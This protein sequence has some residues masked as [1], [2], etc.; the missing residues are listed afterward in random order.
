MT[1]AIVVGIAAGIAAALL[2]LA[3]ASGAGLAF[4]L[5]AMTGLPIAIAGL[6]WGVLAAA[7]S[8]VAGAVLVLALTQWV[9]AAIFLLLF[10]APIVWLTRLAGRSRPVDRSEPGGQRQWYP[11][12]RLLVHAAVS[13]AVGLVLIGAV[14]GYEPET[15]VREATVALVDWLASGNPAGSPP[16]AAEVEPFVRFNVAILPAGVAILA[17]VMIVSDLWLAALVAR[18][19]GR[20]DR[21]RERLWTV[22]LAN[23]VLPGFAATTVLALAPGGLGQAAAVFAGALG[24]AVALVGLAV[25]HALTLGMGGR[26][27]ILAITYVLAFLFGLPLVLLVALGIGESFL[28][29]RARRFGGAPPR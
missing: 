13:I 7:L 15:L 19:S 6:G 24:C 28:H 20:L 29:L 1:Q 8:A 16:T 18:A 3:P 12:G 26:G 5:F 22:T 14:T 10:G 4:P 9:G 23:G 25:L 21:P 17:L 11:L 27:A 2:F